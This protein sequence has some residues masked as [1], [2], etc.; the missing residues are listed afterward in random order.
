MYQR[1]FLKWAG[2]KYGALDEVFKSLPREG[3]CLVEPFVGSATVAL[4]TDY[5]RY[6][7]ND[8]NPDLIHLYRQVVRDVDN[9]IECAQE[10]YHPSNNVRPQFEALR[11]EYNHTQCPDRRAALFL[12]LNR[13]CYNGLMRYNNSGGFNTSFGSYR[14]PLLQE[15][16]MRFF[17]KKFKRAR[18]ECG[19][20][21][22]FR[23]LA[24]GVAYY[25]DPPYLPLSK[26]ASF[27]S[28]TKAGFHMYDHLRL[29]RQCRSVV[30][31][32]GNAWV[33]N[34][35]TAILDECYPNYASCQRFNVDRRISC[36]GEER[37]SAPE[38]IL[39]Y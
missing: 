33:S 4:N 22:E 28:Y 10:L 7:L 27:A 1:S 15:A 30:R 21:S 11:E 9:V 39:S 32:G 6:I 14:Q 26:T 36:K 16:E 37:S 19:D 8:F 2:G 20:F 34:H 12:Y 31:R 5:D 25:C 13:H 3:V 24:K 17:A 29:D 23:F 18:F 35:A 38:V